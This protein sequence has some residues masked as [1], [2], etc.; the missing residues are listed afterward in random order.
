MTV[1]DISRPPPLQTYDT[2]E[3]PVDIT[4]S[5]QLVANSGNME[6]APSSFS[7]T[8]AGDPKVVISSSCVFDVV[9][10]GHGLIIVAATTL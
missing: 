6:D 2:A 9:F 1:L 7:I 10:Q 4:E 8:C 5:W 3:H